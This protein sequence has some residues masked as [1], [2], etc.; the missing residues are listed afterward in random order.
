MWF[1]SFIPDSLLL[2]IINLVLI[3]GLLG[4]FSSYFIR[5]IPPLLPYASIVK[6]VGIVLLVAGVWLRGGYDVEMAWRNKVAEL[7]AKVAEAQ[8]KS[9]KANDELDKAL[10]EK[11]K[12]VKEVQVVIQERI[13]TVEKKIDLE[14]KVAPEAISI[15]ND[16][17]LNTKGAIK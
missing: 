11:V 2:W 7:E 5:F 13:R 15:L 6:T 16:S 14:C 4:T 9:D 3:T 10:K 12:V 17:A 1:L 8:V